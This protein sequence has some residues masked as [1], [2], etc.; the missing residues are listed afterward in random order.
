MCKWIFFGAL[1]FAQVCYRQLIPVGS[2]W[3]YYDQ[4]MAPPGQSNQTWKDLA[5]DVSSWG[6]GPAELG[7][8][9]GD[10]STVIDPSTIT[11]YFRLLFVAEDPGDFDWLHLGLTYDDG[12]IVYLARGRG[13][14]GQYAFRSR[15]I[16]YVCYL[17]QC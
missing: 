17:Q 11:G 14:A 1:L 13:M 6:S 10:E 3:T 7:Y 9:D 16:Q 8:G 12:A 2:T 15:D 5:Y 4:G